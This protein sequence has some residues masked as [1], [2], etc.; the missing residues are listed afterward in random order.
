[1]LRRILDHPP[2]DPSPVIMRGL[3]SV[4]DFIDV[5][6][7]ASG[8]LAIMEL[9]QP[10]GRAFNV[11]TGRAVSVSEV[12]EKALKLFG[13]PRTVEFQVQAA[14]T[15]DIPYIVGDPESLF[16]ESG[17]KAE[18]PLEDSLSSILETPLI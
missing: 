15:D 10:V 17:W 8:Y 7:V 2:G 18:F 12:V 14:S 4:R 11:C 3:N 16:S 5:R 13:S 6:D 1:M 9:S